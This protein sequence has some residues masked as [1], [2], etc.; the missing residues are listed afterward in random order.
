MLPISLSLGNG[1][2]SAAAELAPV[3]A[4]PVACMQ[5]SAARRQHDRKLLF[6]HPPAAA[7]VVLGC[8]PCCAHPP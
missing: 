2:S 1:H 8:R 5:I 4:L 7:A 6:R 3:L